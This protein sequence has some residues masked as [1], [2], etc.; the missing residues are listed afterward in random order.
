MRDVNSYMG[1]GMDRNWAGTCPASPPLCAGSLPA[2]PSVGTGAGRQERA[3]YKAIIH[4]R[5]A[6]LILF[7]IPSSSAKR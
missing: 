5:G 3:Q 6:S 2:P 1:K 7:R 4:C